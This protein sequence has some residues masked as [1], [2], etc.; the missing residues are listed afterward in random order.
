MSV[1]LRTV[2][3][4][5]PVAR[6]GLVP[7][8]GLVLAFGLVPATATASEGEALTAPM[9]LT[10]ALQARSGGPLTLQDCV[11]IALEYNR[12]MSAAELERDA[13]RQGVSAA[14]GTW[15]PDVGVAALRTSSRGNTA[16][17]GSSGPEDF[18]EST[19]TDL[20]ARVSQRLPLGGAVELRYDFTEEGDDR[21]GGTGGAVSLRQPLLRNAGWKRATASVSQARL[22]VD[23]ED[24]SWRSRQ[25]NVV[26]RVKSAYYEVLRTHELIQVNQ[27]AI[28]R[29]QQLLAFSEAKVAAKLATRRDVLSAEIILAQDRSRL[30][31][32]ETEHENALDALAN[33]LGIPVEQRMELV[34]E[35]LA[36]RPIAVQES[37]WVQHAL[38]DNPEV[39]RT[40]SELEFDALTADV[41]GNARLP[42]LDFT[43]LY[44]ETRAPHGSAEALVNVHQRVRT[45]QG[46]VEISFPVLNRTLGSAHR[47]A[48]LRQERSRVLVEEAERQTK[49][50]VRQA[51]RNLQ[52]IEER[53]A[54]LDKEIQGAREKVEYATVNFQLG[55]AS[56]LDIT[57]A[58]EDLVNAESDYVDEVVDYRVELARLEE[59]LGGALME[60]PPPGSGR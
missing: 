23:A 18:V 4:R 3:W 9:A 11:E 47:A 7:A 38:R 40:R 49:L 15:W 2:T 12:L 14:L 50:R 21:I 39:L 1:C 6:A 27:Q 29:D 30:V 32:A 44:G 41:A 17:L 20:V 46:G 55:R 48:T 59:L 57:D 33:V 45:W 42:Q 28:A 10:A 43:L 37:L 26:F 56:N 16:D 52:R 51:A 35:E 34:Q 36:L 22:A 5:C 31:N 54:V 60:E 53:I 19:A 25:L 13:V 58:Q 8:L 24:A